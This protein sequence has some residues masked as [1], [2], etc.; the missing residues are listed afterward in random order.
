MRSG[1]ARLKRRVYQV[2]GLSEVFN[3]SNVSI[4]LKSS[5]EKTVSNL[6]AIAVKEGQVR[7]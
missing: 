3:D 7:S 4:V 2:T 1:T 6:S 5:P